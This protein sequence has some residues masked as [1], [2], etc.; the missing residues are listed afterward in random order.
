MPE[1]ILDDI[2]TPVEAAE[3]LKMD[4]KRLLKLAKRGEIPAKKIGRGDYRFKASLIRDWLENWQGSTYDPNKRA[5]DII[6]AFN[7]TKKKR[8]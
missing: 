8:I 3:L 6:E 1:A 7:G 2:L 5:G 4:S